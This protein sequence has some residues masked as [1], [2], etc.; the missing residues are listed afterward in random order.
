MILSAALW[1]PFSPAASQTLTGEWAIASGGDIVEQTAAQELKKALAGRL[2]KEPAITRAPGKARMIY[3]GTPATS[4]E[5]AAEHARAPFRLNPSEPE[6][7]HLAARGGS[8]YIAGAGPKGAMNGVF[9]FLEKNTSD[10]GA[11]DEAGSPAFRLRVGGHIYNQWPPSFWSQDEQAAYYASHYINVIWGEKYEPPLPR[12]VRRRYGL[13]VMME[14][15]FPPEKGPWMDRAENAPAV[16]INPKNNNRRGISPF[17]AKGREAYAQRYR[18]ALKE[19]PDVKVL[20]GT[21]ADYNIIPSEA[22]VNIKTGRPYGHSRADG[23]KEILAIMKEVIGDRDIQPAVWLWHAFFGDPEGE[24]AFMLEMAQEGVAVIFNEAGNNDCWLLCR[25][26]FTPAAVRTDGRGA[27]LYG[28]H[29]LPLVSAGGACES[30]NPVIA[31]PLPAVAAYK[32]ARLADIDAKNFILW[33]AGLEGWVYQPNAEVIAHMTWEPRAFDIKN[34]A[35]LDPVT[36]EPL[37]RRIAERDFGAVLAPRVLEFWQAFDR[38][39]VWN[40]AAYA[41]DFQPGDTGLHIMDWYQRMGIFTE[42]SAFGGPY[43]L[44]LVPDVLAERKEAQN[45]KAWMHKPGVAENYKTVLA[46]LDAAIGKIDDLCKTAAPGAVASR[47]NDMRRWADLYRRLLTTQY[48]FNRAA[49]AM[50]AAGAAPGA[51]PPRQPLAPISDI[52]RD[53]IDNATKL[54]ALLRDFYPEV[55]ITYNGGEVWRKHAPRRR[56]EEIQ[57]LQT[58]IDAMRDWLESGRRPNL[59]L[60]KRAVG[61]SKEAETLA[62]ANAVDGDGKTRWSSAY[63]DAQWLEVDLGAVHP[64]TRVNIGWLKAYAKSYE[65][66]VATN[67]KDWRTV[68]RTDTGREGR[69]TIALPAG[70]HARQVRIVMKKRG[71]PWGYSI[72]EFEVH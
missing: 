61:S 35:P 33:W 60:K 38:A 23:I 52:A 67:G 27:T 25:D 66:R 49:T 55:N 14:V 34:P 64:L 54:I 20:Y 47:L 42:Y 16:Y 2:G 24:K 72:N 13:G 41:K 40:R 57:L 11:L 12:D 10:I 48:H 37:L 26:N 18:E 30:T 6:S 44:P 9:R 71:S 62:A 28:E 8:L 46:E 1:L 43:H 59:A 22:F 39:V 15:R 70:T 58:K 53:E 29:Y 5:I 7:Y 19:N 69:A 50:L 31:M 17:D 45:A 4:P 3:I 21:F 63:S 65:I 32:L 56:D 36:G 51:A 68:W